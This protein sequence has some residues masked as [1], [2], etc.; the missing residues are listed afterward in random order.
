MVSE[1]KTEYSPFARLSPPTVPEEP[2]PI[3]PIKDIRAV[4]YDIPTP[5]LLPMTKAA[6]R[7]SAYPPREIS[8]GSLRKRHCTA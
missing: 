2:V 5:D 8:P 7:H 4:P 3:V 1:D 6:I